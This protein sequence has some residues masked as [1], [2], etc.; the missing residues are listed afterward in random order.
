M[1]SK[2]I[3][4]SHKKNKWIRFALYIVFLHTKK[5]VVSSSL[6]TSTFHMRS[7]SSGRRA[8]VVEV[9]SEEG[10]SSEEDERMN[11]IKP[12]LTRA[13]NIKKRRELG[14]ASSIAVS[15]ARGGVACPFPW[16]LHDMLDYVHT[17]HLETTVA[18]DEAGQSFAVFNAR[19]F[20]DTIL[21]RCVSLMHA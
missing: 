7:L 9:V 15:I 5:A 17:N 8:V 3:S 19:A 12:S 10:S 4:N 16:K 6:Q 2:I 11:S 20:V 14:F 21:P 13:K 18:W 1:V